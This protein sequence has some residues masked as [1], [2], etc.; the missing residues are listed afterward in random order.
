MPAPGRSKRAEFKG[1]RPA[2]QEPGLE[3]DYVALRQICRPVRNRCTA[4]S[5]PLCTYVPMPKP[6]LKRQSDG[7]RNR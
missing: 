4:G 3:G 6:K 7:K 1:R 2:Q 5:Q